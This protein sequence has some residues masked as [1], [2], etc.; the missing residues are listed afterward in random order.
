MS[1]LDPWDLQRTHPP[2]P[3]Q[4]RQHPCCLPKV[5]SL[6]GVPLEAL[7]DKLNEARRNGSRISG[8]YYFIPPDNWRPEDAEKDQWRKGRGFPYELSQDRNQDGYRD[9]EGLIW[10]WDHGERSG[11]RHWDIQKGGKN[12]ETVSHTGEV[13]KSHR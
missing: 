2:N 10:T 8:R 12:Y 5:P 3:D 1:D 11:E 4:P 7:Y 6:Q 9:Y 13:L